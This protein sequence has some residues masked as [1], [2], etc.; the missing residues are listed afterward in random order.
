[1]VKSDALLRRLSKGNVGS[2]PTPSVY[3]N[4]VMLAWRNGRRG[5]LKIYFFLRVSVQV[6]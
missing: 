2:N 6:R 4:K 5:R 3:G 1:V